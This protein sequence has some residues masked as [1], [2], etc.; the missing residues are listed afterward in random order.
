MTQQHLFLLFSA[1]AALVSVAMWLDYFRKIDVFEKEPPG[2]LLIALAIGGCTPYISLF[3]YRQLTDLGFVE[4]GRF[5]NDLLYA[6]FGIGLNEELSKMIGVVLALALFRKKINEPIDVLVYAGVTALGFSLVENYYYFNNYGIRIISSR[7]FYSALEHII[8][9][10]IIVY[11]LFRYRLFKK[12]HPLLNS[13][14]GLC[15]AI[16]SHGLFDF[17]L[18]DNIAGHFTAFLSVIVYLVGI[19]FWIQM[20]NNA[21]NYSSFFDYDKIHHSSRLVSRLFLWYGLTLVI[22]FVNNWIAADLKLAGITLFSSLVSDGFLFF[23]VILRVSRFKIFRLKY[24]TVMPGLPFYITKNSDEDFVFPF[25]NLPIK[26]KG[27]SFR[28]YL[29]T[30][31]LNRSLTLVPVVT[32]TNFLQGPQTATIID[33]HLLFDDVVVYS[34]TIPGLAV[35]P[36]TV[37]VLKPETRRLSGQYPTAG[38]YELEIPPGFTELKELHYKSLKL[39]DR[40]YLEVG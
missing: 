39:L 25:L 20:L 5:W 31:F 10:S 1:L 32:E 18:Q 13:L 9:T 3:V 37:L 21:N 11:G 22:A 16:A 36:N 34:V 15:I 27:E 35:K 19:N 6:V 7:T 8:N 4:N 23:V 14:T 26:I 40:V 12:G 2:P 24:F 30:R 29:P 38:L 33:K 17:F 28:E